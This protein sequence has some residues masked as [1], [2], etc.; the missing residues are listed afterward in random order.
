M[1]RRKGC[2]PT[3]RTR[4]A[5]S[6]PLSASVTTCATET[7]PRGNQLPGYSHTHPPCSPVC[8][9]RQSQRIGGNSMVPHVFGPHTRRRL[10]VIGDLIPLEFQ[11]AAPATT[12]TRVSAVEQSPLNGSSALTWHDLRPQ[13]PDRGSGHPRRRPHRRTLLPLPNCD[14]RAGGTWRVIGWVITGPSIALT[15]IA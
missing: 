10:A 13:G 12:L 7:T 6:G 2:C 3:G 9:F 11:P 14:D 5:A 8:F 4:S 1:G 15:A